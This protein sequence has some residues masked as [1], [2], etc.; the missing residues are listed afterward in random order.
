MSGYAAFLP[1]ARSLQNNR[2]ASLYSDNGHG[3]Y[4]RQRCA[5]EQRR[6]FP[7]S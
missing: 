4:Y 6:L 5:H 3:R 2:V 7:P 1:L